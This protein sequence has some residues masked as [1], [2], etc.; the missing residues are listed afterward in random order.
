M[1]VIIT[2]KILNV[3]MNYFMKS[4]WSFQPII[5]VTISDLRD[6]LWPNLTSCDPTLWPHHAWL[7]S[8]FFILVFFLLNF[9]PNL[10][11]SIQI[12]EKLQICCE[13]MVQ[14]L[15]CQNCSIYR[16]KTCWRCHWN[17]KFCAETNYLALWKTYH[18]FFKWGT[19]QVNMAKMGSKKYKYF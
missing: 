15:C 5:M 19:Q 10:K 8:H 1:M 11:I 6:R 14:Y 4:M 2:V 13:Q 18:F 3:T 9:D 17:L 16:Q 7:E 12:R